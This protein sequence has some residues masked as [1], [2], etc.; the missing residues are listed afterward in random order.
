MPP[1]SGSTGCAVSQI[2]ISASILSAD[3]G[4]LAEEV[5]AAEEAGCD[6][7]HFD[8]MD[9]QFV[10]NITVGVPVLESVRAATNL[11]IDVHMMVREPSRFCDAFADAGGDIFTV[12]VEAC[13]DVAATIS[14]ARR[15][16]MR[17]AVS[18]KPA[19]P[20]ADVLGLLGP[21]DRVL[22]MSVEP[23][24]GGQAFIPES[25]P[26]IES[27]RALADDA[28]QKIEIAV[29]GGIKPDTIGPA[30]AAGAETLI[31]GSGVFTASGDV[32]AA[33]QALRAAACCPPS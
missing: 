2:R 29:D 9:G 28:G 24:F 14:S 8:V 33:V 19:T 6:E 22:V 12:H 25:L 32:R 7:I 3:F 16:G 15:A 11:P 20:L 1:A 18:L 30:V 13:E 4:R 26:K 21:V 27:L 23:G 17:P 10:P 31:S 5:R